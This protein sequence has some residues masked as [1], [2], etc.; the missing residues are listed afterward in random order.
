MTQADWL[1]LAS[2]TVTVAAFVSL[3]AWIAVYTRVAHWWRNPVGQTLVVKTAIIALL[4][5]PTILSLFFHL[6][7]ATSWAAGWV[8]VALIG[9][10]TPV[11]AWRIRVWIRVNRDGSTG[12]IAAGNSDS[13]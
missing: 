4:L 8:D 6:N 7:R 1:I 12:R 5:I 9:A 11:M 3:T 10:I 2:K 13:Q